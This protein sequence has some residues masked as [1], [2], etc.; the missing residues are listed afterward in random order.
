[1]S[2]RNF[3]NRLRRGLAAA[4][5]VLFHTLCVNCCGEDW[6]MW[7]HDAQRSGATSEELP[8]R[9]YPS[10][11]I[12]LPEPQPAWREEP[13]L[14]FDPAY[15]PVVAGCQLFVA[16]AVDGSI[17]AFDIETGKQLWRFYTNG[18]VR[19][20]PVVW[21]KRVIAGSDDGYLYALDARTGKL[22]WRVAGG[23]L[24]DRHHLGNN[25]LVS[26]QAVRG[27]PV[28]RDGVVY[29]AAGF[30]PTLGVYIR[31]VD[32]K[33]G[34]RVWVND[35]VFYI[36]EV[37]IDHNI[38]TDAAL[39]PQG[40]LLISGDKLLVPNGRSMPAGLDVKTG[41][42][43]YYVQGYRNGHCR[44]V[45]SDR[46]AFVGTSAVVDIETG[47]EVGSK[48]K[49][50]G[51]NA[52]KG[53][54][55]S[56]FDLFEGPYFPYK[57]MRGCNAWSVVTE[58][59]VYGFEGGTFYCYDLSQPRISEYTKPHVGKD[60][61]P[62]RWDLPCLWKLKT[63]YSGTQCPI[64]KAGSRLYASAGSRLLALQIPRSDG[65]SPRIAWSLELDGEPVSLIAANGK[66]I[67]STLD[68]KLICL[69]GKPAGGQVKELLR[70]ADR[71]EGFVLLLDVENPAKWVSGLLAKPNIH[72]IVIV[73]DEKDADA[74]RD[75]LVSLEDYGKRVEV[76]TGEA[77]SFDLPPYIA[78]IIVVPSADSSLVR[79]L[80]SSLRPYGGVLMIQG[81]GAASR[82]RLENGKVERAGGWT[83]IRREGPLPG[84]AYWTHECADAA[85]T[86][87][88]RDE[89]V[90]APLGILWYGDGPGYGFFKWKD[91]G[92]GV[93]PQVVCGRLFALRQRSPSTL[94][95]MDV[96]TGRRL[97][98]RSV[99]RF[100]RYA[101]LPDAVIVVDG[102]RYRVLDPATGEPQL[103][104]AIPTG[105]PPS[106]KPIARDIRV[107]GDI[108]V[109]SVGFGEIQGKSYMLM[110]VG[111]L[112][113]AKLLVALNRKTGKPLWRREAQQRF[114]NNALAMGDGMVFCTD[115]LSPVE[116]ARR[117]RR[118]E[119]IST[120][121][122]TIYALDAETGAVKWQKEI[123]S[124]YMNFREGNWL[125]MRAYDDWLAYS[126]SC[127]VLLAGRS[128]RIYA[129][130]AKTG[131]LLWSNEGAGAQP[132]IVREK[133]CITQTG[134]VFDIRKGRL[135][136]NMPGRG[137]GCNYF[138]AGKHLQF[139]RD[140]FVSYTNL[141]S[142]S[143][144]RTWLRNIRSGCSASLIPADGILNAPCFSFGCVC[145]YP[146]QTSF[147][148][149]TMP[150]V[151]RWAKPKSMRRSR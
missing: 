26:F 83:V 123:E 10:W 8:D 29:F 89:R 108:A 20:A 126:A 57:F 22:L 140:A 44:V 129:L 87:Y 88:S 119:Q 1:M 92:S 117:I 149:V 142:P 94:V 71:E 128:R 112:W 15:E 127:K 111:G 75:N 100:T 5:W 107:E 120:V 64:V 6:A 40:Y 104:V 32:A 102:D 53:F 136:G 109:V 52:P 54:D 55:A 28:V 33:T 81:G 25:R 147:A 46:Y 47:R 134:A 68:G 49:E 66:L 135:V 76:L 72:I 23:D 59:R 148:M 139:V 36:P 98:E 18:P 30:W 113:D 115:S 61:H 39:S 42:L 82:A 121:T 96:Y 50:A 74:L 122:S 101:S 12:E 73:S 51:E 105:K 24:T 67:A 16:S 80:F 143:L 58:N 13:R 43:L 41:K 77:K 137:K 85:R 17:R 103:D 45:A 99:G 106:E 78:D 114:N 2:D 35:D 70:I 65:A 37:R 62:R 19:F 7:R 151:S 34:R 63:P 141:D 4:I 146:V 91:Y 21:E 97:W 48:W 138:I 31:A 14:L 132:V 9:L 69:A 11:T 125:G 130:D 116:G 79:K 56:K 3:P 145:N 27:G 131:K 95:A 118:G 84:S 150:E 124:P 60:F 90:K 133:T 144:E 86:F 38:L 110:Q 93:K